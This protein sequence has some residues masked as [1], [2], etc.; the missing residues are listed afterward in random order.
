MKKFLF[1]FILCSVY[2]LNAK[3]GISSNN[4][5]PKSTVTNTQY[6]DYYQTVEARYLSNTND[7]TSDGANGTIEISNNNLYVNFDPTW[8]YGQQITTGVIAYINI[9]PVLPTIELG[10]IYGNGQETGYYA[11][12]ENNNLVVYTPNNYSGVY[13]TSLYFGISID[14]NCAKTWY[15]DMDGDGFGDPNSGA[16]TDCYQPNY[17]YVD[18]SLDCNDQN[19]T[20]TEMRNWYVDADNDG[21]GDGL[22]QNPVASCQKPSYGN[23]ASN[24]LDC[25]DSNSTIKSATVWY[26]D[27]DNDGFGDLDAEPI[28]SCTKPTGNYATNKFDNCPTEPYPSNNGC[29]PTINDMD[30]NYIYVVSPTIPSTSIDALSTGQ[31][32][33]EITY[34]DGLGRPMQ[35]IGI[36]A[37]GNEEDIITHLEYDNFGRQD[38]EYLPYAE[39][40]DK[41]LIRTG[42]ISLATKNFYNTPKYENT[43]NPY[44]QKEFEASSLN[45]VLKQAAPGTDW[46]LGGG[47]EV[48][49]DYQTNVD[50][51]Q[52][53]RFG[54]VFS[55][56]NRENPNIKDNGFYEPY[57]LYKTI[58]KDENW[59]SNQINPDDH[60]TQEF[61]D[62]KDRVVLKR[63][64]DAGKWHDTY[65]VYD[66]FGNLT[67]VL[68]P[69][70][71]VYS[72][73]TQAYTGQSTFRDS[74][75]PM[76]FFTSGN[77]YAEFYMVSQGDVISLSL[78]TDGAS[79]GAVLKS[80]KIADL[81]FSPDL[82]DMSFGNIMVKDVNG[83][84]VVG[85]TAYIQGGDLY[86]SSTGAGVYDKDPYGNSILNVGLTSSLL[87]Y[88]S[89]YA[90]PVL[91]AAA[92][93]LMYQYRYDKRNRLVEKKLPGKQWEYI[94]YDKLDRPVLTQDA[95]L[96]TSNKWLFT[97]YDVFGR[98]AYTGV[99][100][101][102]TYLSRTDMQNYF[103]TQNNTAGKMYESKAA[104]GTGYDN[105]YYSNSNFPTANIEL[106]AISYYDNYTFDKAGIAVPATSLG[107]DIINYDNAATTQSLTKG[108]PTGTKT[109]VLDPD[110][111]SWITSLSGYDEKGRVIYTAKNNSYLSTVDVVET[112]L[113]FVGKIDKTVTTHTKGNN[114]PIVIE[115]LFTYDNAGRLKKQTQELNNT[116]VVEVITENSYDELGQLTSKKVG[117][118]SNLGLQTVNYDYNIRG[119]LK[120]INNPNNLG[121]DLFGFSLDY[122]VP[123]VSTTNPYYNSPPLYNGNISSVSWKTNNT[124]SNT[125][126]YNYT[127]DALNRFKNAYYAENNV[128]TNHFFEG[129]T[130][131]DRNGNITGL[132]RNFPVLN[133]NNQYAGYQYMDYLTYSYN[134][135]KLIRVNDNGSTTEG[136][137][138]GYKG[139]LDE[140][141]YDANGNMIKDL[142]KG[143][144]NSTTDGIVYNHLNLPTKITF[145]AG[146]TIDYVYDALGVKQ[147]KIVSTGTTTNYAGGFQYEKAGTG[148][149]VL[150]FFPQPEGY[151]EYNAGTFNYIYQ[152]KDHLGNIRLSYADKNNDGIIAPGA[153]FI[154][155]TIWEDGFESATGWDG[156]GASWGH[157]LDAFD[158]TVK[159]S[160]SRSGRIDVHNEDSFRSR[161]V[162]STQWIAIDNT[163]DTKYRVS[164]WFFIQNIPQYSR[165]RLELMMKKAGET[166]YMTLYEFKPVTVKGQWVYEEMII[167]VPAHIKSLNSRIA[168]DYGGN[169]S[170]TTGSAWYDDLKIEKV[171]INTQNEIIAENNYYPF[172]LKHNDNN[173]VLNST[174]PAQK[175]K[176][177]GKELQDELGFNMYDY[178]ARNYDPALG[179]WMNID[180]LAEKMRRWSPYN[181]CFNN[182]MHFVDPDGMMAGPF[183]DHFDMAGN[184]LYTDNRETNNIIIDSNQ[185]NPLTFSPFEIKLSDYKFNK[186]NYSTLSK[187]GKYYGIAIGMDL[188]KVRNG[189]ISVGNIAD[190]ENKG[191]YIEGHLE[192]FNG[193]YYKADDTNGGRTLMYTNH[194]KR[195]VAINLY[196]GKV[197]THLDDK[198]NFMSVM[199]H[200]G[201]P[202]GHLVNPN[203]KHSDIYKDQISKYG[204]DITENFL[205]FLETN[206]TDYKKDG[207]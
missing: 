56:G 120:N 138:D 27:T 48:K 116:N 186:S 135:N 23:Y 173:N 47:H 69:Q 160:G 126:Q 17:G 150:K 25:D 92:A 206:Y 118:K 96:K 72:S 84:S 62:K 174:N 194:E 169:P 36:A 11:K 8:T 91:N 6:P 1:I 93:D 41:G 45:R 107:I 167:T 24:N 143:I 15:K 9:Y 134:G 162:H 125:K 44:S 124:N 32:T 21:Y 192:G 144:G 102:S 82:P 196:D 129:I 110:S 64:F 170:P 105:S 34:F 20:I 100:T 98:V 136:F 60:T 26:V 133:S 55:E 159:H 57:Q 53:R 108:L 18:N 204:K 158:T 164:G 19:H 68:P 75:T 12:I 115:D 28:T 42:N 94:V 112:A 104:S 176:Y 207:D 205:K 3:T 22:D 76:D 180:P 198:Y 97:K 187:I 85:G 191:S 51:D 83:N 88:Q 46:A 189:M 33:E 137:K 81:D 58:I 106:Y 4:P 70:V 101:N 43:T 200:E 161:A 184:F 113:D 67:Y 123:N 203:K 39:T 66:D 148:T 79:A 73:I 119:W 89:Q 50:S 78:F 199:D 29:Q 38:K 37:G 141:S 87:N 145:N 202:I 30:E 142:N 197:S 14:L 188:G 59:L 163:V 182:P 86:F 74:D 35:K 154:Y 181:Y 193:G 103:E 63:T 7:W 151:V 132:H 31:K 52:I 152:Y 179:R 156:T 140:Y 16:F 171:I 122:N 155:Q 117:G 114:T 121:S 147:R 80:G 95:N 157:P 40:S 172:G 201:G 5:I 90:A 111:P 153:P 99:H 61:K 177:N 10:P 149:E 190:V 13:Y 166:E 146:G 71:F 109:K 130:G 49:F 139:T 195:M 77:S 183:D 2:C 178:G 65:Y 168:F 128:F 131:Y 175:Y 165:A 127:Y 54:V 185:F